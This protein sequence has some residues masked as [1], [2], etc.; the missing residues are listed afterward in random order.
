MGLFDKFKKSN[1]DKST[2][3]E[4]KKEKT[5]KDYAKIA[6]DVFFWGDS[7]KDFGY[8]YGDDLLTE[9][10]K[11]YPN[12]ANAYYASAWVYATLAKQR[13]T[14]SEQT[15]EILALY[16]KAKSLEFCDDEY[17]FDHDARIL[18]EEL[19]IISPLV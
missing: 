14:L 5:C 19:N 8:E 7:P 17:R 15:F 2:K 1:N 12:D 4:V 10:I 18:L 9:W 13:N 3:T 16:S 11:K 6:K